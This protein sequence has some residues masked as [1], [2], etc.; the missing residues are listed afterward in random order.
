[1][2][3]EVRLAPPFYLRNM[4]RL[5]VCSAVVRESETAHKLWLDMPFSAENA[6]V[7]VVVRVRPPA[8]ANVDASRTVKVFPDQPG[9]INI[10]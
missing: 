4:C 9:L 8:E 1:M 6:R 3:C 5:F 2:I 7:S 10:K